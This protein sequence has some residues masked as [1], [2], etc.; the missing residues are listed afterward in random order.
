MST[1]QTILYH[2]DPEDS[3]GPVGFHL[4]SDAFTGAIGLEFDG[5]PFEA[6]HQSITVTIPREWAVMLGLVNE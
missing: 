1:R 5:V 6:T 2:E 4:F 3:A